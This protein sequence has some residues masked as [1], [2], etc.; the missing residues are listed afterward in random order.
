MSL[1]L[2]TSYGLVVKKMSWELIPQKHEAANRSILIDSSSTWQ[3]QA[4]RQRW[5]TLPAM[6]ADGV[7]SESEW[8]DMVRDSYHAEW[9][10]VI[11]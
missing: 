5:G 1:R 6:D 11:S 2:R 8:E 4:K 7:S 9:N 3:E 10:S